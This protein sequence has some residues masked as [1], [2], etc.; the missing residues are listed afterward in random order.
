MRPWEPE[1]RG[2]DRPVDLMRTAPDRSSRITR[3]AQVHDPAEQLQ[4]FT[5]TI[6]PKAIIV[7][8]LNDV[9]MLRTIRPKAIIVFILND[10][11]ML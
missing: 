11:I 10:V 7:F 4:A 2:Q 8:I 9:I 3:R 1:V 6:R 5:R